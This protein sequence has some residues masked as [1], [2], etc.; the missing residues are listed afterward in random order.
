MVIQNITSPANNTFSA[1]PDAGATWHVFALTP[2]VYDVEL[3]LNEIKRLQ[4]V[5]GSPWYIADLSGNTALDFYMLKLFFDQKNGH[6]YWVVGNNHAMIDISAAN[7]LFYKF[8][9]FDAQILGDGVSYSYTSEN[10]AELYGHNADIYFVVPNITLLGAYA[11]THTA[12]IIHHCRQ[13]APPLT[14]Q[15]ET[16]TQINNV[17][18]PVS[19]R[20]ISEIEVMLVNGYGE[21]VV[22]A[23]TST[24]SHFS[25][26]IEISTM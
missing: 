9:G 21:A 8:I 7:G 3:L 20:Y 24:D 1:S 10:E 19:D 11:N 18:I 16:S 23:S 26:D 4:Q 5:A 12:N 13:R 14:L 22:L 25:A 15:E 2:G 17:K 6:S